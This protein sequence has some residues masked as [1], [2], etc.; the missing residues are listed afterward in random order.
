MLVE[1]LGV[2][3]EASIEEYII[4]P[5]DEQT[6]NQETA[7]GKD[8]IRLHRPE[9][10]PSRVAK[11]VTGHS[12]LGLV[13]RQ[14]SLANQSIPLMDPLVPL[15]NS[16]HEKLPESGSMHFSN[17]GSIFNLGEHHGKTD[18]CWD[19]ESHRDGEDYTSDAASI[20]SDDD[21]QSPLLSRQMTGMDKDMAHSISHGN[22]LSVGHNGSLV[23]GNETVSHADIGGGWQLVWKWSEKVGEDGKR[24]GG[25]QRIYL[26][27]EAALGSRHGSLL[28]VPAGGIPE[29]GELLQAAALV[30]QPALCSRAL[31]SR[32]SIGPAMVHPSETVANEQTW[33]HL[34][35]PGVK[36]ALFV[37]VGLQILQQVII[38]FLHFAVLIRLR[39][40][41]SS[42]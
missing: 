20:N 17:T 36:R 42:N 25:F 23:Q 6:D 7:A 30:S 1:G 22:H 29:E 12:F 5:T 16:V 21:L 38:N 35:E 40:L 4:G 32:H 24:G 11:S 13:S 26:N 3:A 18:Q 41:I 14:G 27:Q 15:F 28:S 8:Q 37:G 31:M 33:C 10:G 2:V 34:L 9:E 39:F 19:E